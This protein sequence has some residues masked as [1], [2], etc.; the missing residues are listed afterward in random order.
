MTTYVESAA[1]VAEGGRT[2]FTALIVG[3]LFLVSLIFTPIFAAIPAF[4]TTPALLI[5]GVFMMAS[6]TTINWQDI[7]EAIPAF[8]TIFFIPFG[9]SIAEGLALGLITYPLI[10]TFAGR[11]QEVPLVTWILAVI[12]IARFIFM[13]VQ[14]G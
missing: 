11:P 14:F 8:L 7:T 2:G 1:G 4:A 9:F 12:F 6:I 10:K 13:A 5:V 3:A